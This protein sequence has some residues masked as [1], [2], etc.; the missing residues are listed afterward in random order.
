MLQL[1]NQVARLMLALQGGRVAGRAERDLLRTAVIEDAAIVCST[2]SFS[3]SGAFSRMARAFDVV[4]IDEA[5]QA[6]E[7]STLIPLTAGCKQVS[8]GLR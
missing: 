5:A 4:I 1:P 8:P 7:P 6:V 2:L 3:G